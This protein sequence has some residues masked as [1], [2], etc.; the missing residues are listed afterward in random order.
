MRLRLNLGPAVSQTVL[1]SSR[2]DSSVPLASL[3]PFWLNC[4]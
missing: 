2:P 3:E 1:V 4:N